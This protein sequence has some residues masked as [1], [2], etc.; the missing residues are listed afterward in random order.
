MKLFPVL[1]TFAA[2]SSALS[3]PASGQHVISIGAD[4]DRF[5][6]EL[7]PGETRWVREDEKWELRRVRSSGTHHRLQDY[8]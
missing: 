7:N 4:D 6:I 2:T 3:I 8:G 1:A 5:L